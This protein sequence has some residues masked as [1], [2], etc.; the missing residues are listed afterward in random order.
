MSVRASEH[1]VRPAPVTAIGIAFV[2]LAGVGVVA[3]AGCDERAPT[4]TDDGT[5][6][7]LD[8]GDG[9][10][11]RRADDSADRAADTEPALPL[12]DPPALATIGG[13][14]AMR[15]D[16]TIEYR[17]SM[18][19]EPTRFA[20]TRKWVFPQRVQLTWQPK[21]GQGMDRQRWQR[22]GSRL[23]EFAPRAVA[24]QALAADDD[25][26]RDVVLLDAL[27]RAA[28]LWPD[29][30]DWE[31][32]GAGA[33]RATLVDPL[34]QDVELVAD[35]DERTRTFAARANGNEVAR[36]VASGRYDHP[37][38]AFPEVLEVT[39]GEARWT[40]RLTRIDPRAR[41]EDRLFLAGTTAQP[42]EISPIL[43]IDRLVPRPTL[44]RALDPPTA[45]LADAAERARA[46]LLDVEPGSGGD[47]GAGAVVALELDPSSRC[48]A[49]L[50]KLL[51]TE[52]LQTGDLPPG[53]VPG[54]RVGARSSTLDALEAAE[55][56]RVRRLLQ[57]GG[58]AT[59]NATWPPYL[60]DLGGTWHLVVPAA[61]R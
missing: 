52:D 31:D 22:Y 18:S 29:G 33:Q 4:P 16:G 32:D 12:T 35:G 44:R 39:L 58:P 10:R 40:E 24:P 27:Y 59:P 9:T 20:S 30:F 6:F 50:V 26:T 60:I 11:T 54:P 2:A 43:T 56:D 17:A 49:L 55:L 15:V 34:V 28:L 23:W 1:R 38:R 25:R 57:P 45:D 41:Y 5:I 47:S 61:A 21:G 53:F 8:G 13:V 42:V 46:L 37:S 36:L 14:R 19:D 48:V 3:L 7:A 51:P